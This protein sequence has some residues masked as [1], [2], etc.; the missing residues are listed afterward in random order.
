M[1]EA[2]STGSGGQAA[3]GQAAATPPGP[4]LE[5]PASRPYRG[6]RGR[7]AGWLRV[8]LEPPQ[9]PP[10]GGEGV[11]AFRPAPAFLDYL[12]VSAYLRAGIY[13]AG[14]G[15]A[16][17]LVMIASEAHLAGVGAGFLILLG[18]TAAI[19][20]DFYSLRFRYDTTWYVMTDRALRNRRGIWVITENTVTFDN[21]QN[22]KRRQGPLQRHFGVE[23]LVLETAASGSAGDQGATAQKLLVEGIEDG[24]ELRSRITGRMREVRSRGLGERARRRAAADAGSARG[25]HRASGPESPDSGR[26]AAAGGFSPDHLRLLEEI[27]DEVQGL[28]PAAGGGAAPGGQS[29]VGRKFTPGRRTGDG[30]STDGGGSAPGGGIT[31]S[32]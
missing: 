26:P 7:V 9:S 24:D 13:L 18:T 12:K 17:L 23:T 30:G 8:P 2:G 28:R 27:L 31:A 29:A 32:D 4:A 10:G 25:A 3:A 14:G 21:V 6:M 11:R 22:I 5:P 20:L 1:S 19:A 15:A 16:A